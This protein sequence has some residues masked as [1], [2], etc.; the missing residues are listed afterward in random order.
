MN[1]EQ[2]YLRAHDPWIVAQVMKKHMKRRC[3]FSSSMS[4]HRGSDMV[5][6]TSEALLASARCSMGRDEHED[7]DEHGVQGGRLFDSNGYIPQFCRLSYVMAVGK[8]RI[9]HG[10]KYNNV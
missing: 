9:G 8:E 3:S 5:S 6:T 10:S 2:I 7:E 4:F 1:R